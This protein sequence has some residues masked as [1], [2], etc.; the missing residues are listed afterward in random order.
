MRS[1]KFFR[2]FFLLTPLLFFNAA[3]A[4]ETDDAVP[5]VTARVARISFLRGDV[6]I[7]RAD[8]DDW[9]RA[10]L[11]LPIV[12]GDEITTDR[13]ARV[14]IQFDR[15]SFLRLSENSY[16]K[17]PTL[18]DE[19][20]AVS[21]PQGT[22]SLRVLK[23]EKSRSYFEL[24]A[25]QTTVSVQKAGL[26]RIDAGDKRSNEVR[27]TVNDDGEA[28]VYSENSGFTLRAGR[29]SRVYLS[30]AYA[31]EWET[32]DAARYADEWDEWVLDRDAKIAKKLRDAYYDQYYDRDIYGA[33]DLNEYGEWINTRKYGWVWKP[34]RNSTSS[35]A[36]WSPYRYGHWRWIPPYG[37]TWVNDEPWGWAT[38]HHGRW[39]YYNGDWH[40]SPYGYYR[41]RRSWWKPALVV[42]TYSGNLICWYPLPYHY[43][44]YNYNRN[45]YSKYVDKRKYYNNTTIIVNP[46]PNPTP[47][48]SP[49]PT[50]Q[51]PPISKT[52]R[53]LGVPETAV[54][55]VGKEEFGAIR[56][57][58]TTAPPLIARQILT[59]E[60]ALES[61]PLLP[62]GINERIKAKT[63]IIVENPRVEKIDAPVK[64]GVIERKSGAPMD[65]E[66]RRS[67]VFNDRRIVERP[68]EPVG[69]E[70]VK[71]ER[72]IRNPRD[73]G[74]VERFPTRPPSK[75][76]EIDGETNSEPIK[77]APPRS[78]GNPNENGET[79]RAP[80]RERPVY[81]PRK[82]DE[83]QPPPVY[84]PP[85]REKPRN[86]SPPPQKPREKPR[87]DPP[88][89]PRDEPPP[90]NKQE[91][92]NEPPRKSE[93]EVRTPGKP[94]KDN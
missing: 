77:Q 33:E 23:F 1:A 72:E 83:N 58:K 64:T 91:P 75:R 40:W 32:S 15:D 38:Y 11:N 53:L 93:P 54:V 51:Q 21:L 73:T 4:F 71:N 89:K 19:G 6:Q 31:G 24:D 37:W 42:V 60:P 78:T 36:N 88:P 14:E 56:T 86:E 29:S 20:V 30:G 9:E 28:R 74:A 84:N 13:D 80:R 48:P 45:Y 5:E 22:L 49:T 50:E 57:G 35:Y 70:P 87:S 52:P 90:P 65:A 69:G 55:A 79:V 81:Q 43:R 62:V 25:P 68:N 34:Y 85:P 39:V 7:K 46:T 66:I 94:E 61:P 63:D 12:E 18:R 2:A 26:Y 41:A 67:K 8:S 82:S 59:K 92:R 47:N 27:V 76:D 16:L 10:T 3:F 17:I 44:Y